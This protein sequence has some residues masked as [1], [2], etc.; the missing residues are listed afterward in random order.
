MLNIKSKRIINLIVFLNIVSLIIIIFFSPFVF[1]VFNMNTYRALYIQN[2]V[3][4]QLNEN[5]V[6]KI[7]GNLFD[8]FRYR[9]QLRELEFEQ[10]FNFFEPEEVEHLEDVRVIFNYIF[11]LYI[12]SWIFF[13]VLSLLVI[14]KSTWRNMQIFSYFLI[15]GSAS[16]I[17]V[18]LLLFFFSQN[19]IYLFGNFHLIFFP[20]G[21]WMFPETSLLISLFPLGFFYEFFIKMVFESLIIAAALLVIGL[22]ILIISKYLNKKRQVLIGQ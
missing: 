18:L 20:Q 3:F 15:G 1:N 11:I 10:D 17:S 22:I 16:V 2:S 8:F 7:T 21:N 4:D 14:G 6:K 13:I 5:D 19:F 12:S 9:D